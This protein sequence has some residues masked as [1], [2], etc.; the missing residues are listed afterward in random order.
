[1]RDENI[2]SFS[3]LVAAGGDYLKQSLRE[4]WHAGGNIASMSKLEVQG[5]VKRF[6]ANLVVNQVSFHVEDGEF[7]VLL[8]PSG[9]GKTTILRTICGLEQP[10]E[11]RIL[12]GERDV[13]GLSPRQRNV[14]MVFQD[15]GLYPSMDVY[16]NIAYSLENQHLPKAEVQ[17]RVN[18]AAGKL[19][20]TPLL[21]RTITDL[22]GGEQQ[23][24][25]L[26][27]ILAR[28]ADVFLYDEP[29]ANLDPKLRYQA[30]RDIIAVHQIRQVPSV[31][32]THDQTEAFA[33]GD[34]VAIIAR[35]RLQQVGTPDELL[36]TPAN[37][38]VAGFVGSPPMNLLPGKIG[39]QDTRQ[40]VQVG[41]ARFVLPDK[42]N[43][44]LEQVDSENIVL[45]LRPQALVPEWQFTTL[46]Y[47]PCVFTAEVVE[48]ETLIG[49][50]VVT[51]KLG[52]D[53]TMAAVWPETETIPVSGET[54]RVGVKPETL[55][56][57]NVATE[58][59]LKAECK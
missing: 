17:Q 25:A 40:I 31:Y 43:E 55:S 12:I 48:V 11:G 6:G 33:I 8:G 14:G 9:G 53:V 51:L 39:M 50:F 37:M 45:G 20:L 34:R 1:V 13:T 35:G 47:D 21:R 28:D 15:Y 22:S 27:R 41:D 18:E 44:A 23:R 29:L 38:F 16:G 46:D 24:V 36:D 56:L 30:R 3:L 59:A 19:K 49:E 5:L 42:W 57:F 58:E 4:Y 54:L 52:S 10:D 32:V 2:S 7:F 26:A